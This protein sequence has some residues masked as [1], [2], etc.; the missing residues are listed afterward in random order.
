MMG[1]VDPRVNFKDEII[2]RTQNNDVFRKLRG[3]KIFRN[4]N[5]TTITKSV[6]DIQIHLKY[7]QVRQIRANKSLL[8][9]EVRKQ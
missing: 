9:V 4:V 2:S 5:N 7:C 6:M 3:A 8:K 1:G